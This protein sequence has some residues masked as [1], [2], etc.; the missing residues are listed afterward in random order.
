MLK[1]LGDGDHQAFIGAKL[2]PFFVYKIY[3][4][5]LKLD[6]KFS[7]LYFDIRYLVNDDVDILAF[8]LFCIL[9]AENLSAKNL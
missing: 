9:H 2:T 4:L 1:S 7:F 3:F 6:T 5:N 8:S